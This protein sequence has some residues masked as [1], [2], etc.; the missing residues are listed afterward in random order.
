MLLILTFFFFFFL[1]FLLFPKVDIFFSNLFFHDNVFI[2]EKVLA[3]KV[4]RSFLKDFMVLIPLMALIYL[5]FN[6]INKSQ[7]AKNVMKRRYK[8]LCLGLIVGPIIGSGL[9]A[10]IYFKNT[11]GRARPVQIEEFGGE[12]LFTQPFVKTDQCVKNCSWISG[13]TSAAFSFLTGVIFLKNPFF[14]WVNIFVG[15]LVCF[16]RI[17]MG[18]HFLSDNVFAIIFMIY[19]A[20]A[21]RYTIIRLLKKKKLS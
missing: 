7:N 4:L 11:W 2:S 17:S 5:I 6:F 19:L 18:G 15:L 14:V 1:F 16:C 3:I 8:Y 21:Y 13:E 12:K 10:N 20:I 9:I